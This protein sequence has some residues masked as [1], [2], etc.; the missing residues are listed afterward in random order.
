MVSVLPH[1]TAVYLNMS[2]SN[3]L[4]YSSVLPASSVVYSMSDD[5]T[6]SFVDLIIK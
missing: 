6:E 2:N 3:N 5:K 4:L 1:P